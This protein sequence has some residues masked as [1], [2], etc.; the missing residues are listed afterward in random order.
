MWLMPPHRKIQITDLALA[1]VAAEAGSLAFTSPSRASIA[2]SASPV[3][4]MPTSLRNWRRLDLTQRCEGAESAEEGKEVLLSFILSSLLFAPSRPL[5]LCA[6]S[7][8][9]LTVTKSL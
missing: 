7:S 9:Y 8:G 3:K 5:C 4:P 1:V 6:K 2:P